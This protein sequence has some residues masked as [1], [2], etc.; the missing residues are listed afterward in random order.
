MGPPEVGMDDGCW[1]H[2]IGGGYTRDMA[3]PAGGGSWGTDRFGR[4]G[5]IGGGAVVAGFEVCVIGGG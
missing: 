5:S 1:P 4:G 2:C 3:R